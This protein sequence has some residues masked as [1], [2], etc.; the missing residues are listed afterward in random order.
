MPPATANPPDDDL[1]E[2]DDI[3]DPK[4]KKGKGLD[5][6]SVDM[7]FE[8]ELEE[9]FSEDLAAD[10]GGEITAPEGEETLLLDDIA[11][12]DEGLPDLDADDLAAGGDVGDALLLDDL[13][14]DDLAG[15]EPEP[16]AAPAASE[17]EDD[18]LLLEDLAEDAPAELDGDLD[19][20]LEMEPDAGADDDALLLDDLAPAAGT[21]DD[22]DDLD[23]LLLDEPADESAAEP[24]G[25]DDDLDALLLDEPADESAAAPTPA[26]DADISVPDGLDDLLAGDDSD[27]P[28]LDLPGAES[29]K[30]GADEDDLL[31]LGGLEI[32][33]PEGDLDA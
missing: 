29:P 21:A 15:D 2:L 20:G 13:A 9:L 6:D 17:D 28:G 4:P 1:L 8:Q 25:A 12:G 18:T 33:G 30:G 5:A 16:A 11:E 19:A 27:M 14:M 32:T 22:G 26:D 10:E 31:G 7:S 3:V 23:A 24:A